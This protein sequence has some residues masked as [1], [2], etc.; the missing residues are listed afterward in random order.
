MEGNITRGRGGRLP[1]VVGAVFVGYEDKSD[2]RVIL[3]RI[4]AYRGGRIVFFGVLLQRLCQ[5]FAVSDSVS[6]P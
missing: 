4:D 6:L 3:N 5:G 1:E 2:G